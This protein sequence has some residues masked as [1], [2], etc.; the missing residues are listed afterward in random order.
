MFKSLILISVLSI[1]AFS[2]N[3]PQVGMESYSPGTSSFKNHIKNPDC[4][5]NLAGITVSAGTL[6][7]NT[8]TPLNGDTGTQCNII[9][10]G[11]GQTYCWATN[12]F[13]EDIKGQNCE[14]KFVYK[15]A[16]S[17]SFKAYVTQGTSQVLPYLQ[18][19][20]PTY[21]QSVS[22]NFPCGDLSQATSVCIASTGTGSPSLN[23]AKVY[24]GV[25]TNIGQVAQPYYVGSLTWVQATSCN[26]TFG[27]STTFATASAVSACNF[28]TASGSG[29][30]ALSTKVPGF[31]LDAKP[32][33][34][35][36]IANGFF[37]MGTG[38]PSSFRFTDGTLNSQTTNEY[39]STSDGVTGIIS[40]EITYTSSGNK[41][42]Q[43][44]GTSDTATSSQLL[45]GATNRGL[46]IAVYY[47]PNSSQQVVTVSSIPTSP[48]ITKLTSGTG[49][50]TPPVGTTYLKIKMVGGG[51]GGSGS[52]TSGGAGGA[53][54]GV[55]TFGTSLLTCN[56]GVGGSYQVNTSAGGTATINAPAIGS[57]TSGA[58]GGSGG[59]GTY[60]SGPPGASSPF[61]GAGSVPAFNNAGGSA[62]ANSG[63]G[64]A[65]GAIGSTGASYVGSSGAAGGYIEATISSPSATY[66]YSI[67]AS[68]A[69]GGAGASGFAGGAGGSGVII[70]EENYGSVPVPILVGSVISNS[71]GTERI[72]RIRVSNNGTATIVSQS[73]SGWTV[74]RT[75]AGFVAVA[76]PSGRFSQVPT[77]NCTAEIGSR[78][79][80]VTNLTQTSFTANTATS[81]TAV[82]EDRNF[83]VICM[84]P[85]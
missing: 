1:P 71:S 37:Y 67:G 5:K 40:G 66:P 72:E 69:S 43:L 24:A 73:D 49:T 58:A 65:G 23:V 38:N 20:T 44:S 52:G 14:A 27:N 82:D 76:I 7:K 10:T 46:V 19:A 11:T 47:Y 12:S 29:L 9:S 33:T 75:S 54:G 77:C 61:G 83:S 8:S 55:S 31:S 22:M 36:F 64:G 6:S 80:V 79:C 28:P 39:H 53:T 32:G 84:G 25:A 30:S 57:A 13:S 45:A 60:Q 56:G 48:T 26:W 63:S 78:V 41:T 35:R 74:N 50:Y 18:L 16:T 15:G 85:R 62:V 34:Y 70:I 59:Y 17:G 3:Y 21:S 51:G 68:G 2:Q 4:W 81:T 42:I